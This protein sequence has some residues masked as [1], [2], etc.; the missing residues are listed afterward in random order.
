MHDVFLS[1]THTDKP[2][3]RRI[4]DALARERLTIWW[5]QAINAGETF[6]EVTAQALKDAA[7]IVVLWSKRSIESRWVRS[8]ATFADRAGKLVPVMI[9]P[10][11]RPIQFELTHTVDLL[12]WNGDVTDPRWRALVD[13]IRRLLDKQSPQS[14][15]AGAVPP[16]GAVLAE[17]ARARHR[18]AFVTAIAIALLAAGGW[19]IASHRTGSSSSAAT[20]ASSTAPATEVS[21]AVLPFADLSPAHDQEY[22]SD[23]LTAEI[24]DQLAQVPALRLVGRTSS[25]S[26]KGKN[27][28]LKTIGS[29]LGVT[30]LLE[31]SVRKDGEQLRISAQLVRA[32]DGAQVWSHTYARGLQDVFTAQEEIARD[33]AQALSVTLDVGTLSRAQGGTVNPEAYD[34]W[35][36]IK[37]ANLGNDFRPETHRRVV[38]LAREAV[39]LD[40]QFVLAWDQLA[41]SLDILSGYSEP[42]QDARL[43]AEAAQVRARVMAM[44]P[45]SWI[46]K[47]RRVE[48]ALRVRDWAAAESIA[49]EIL[50]SEPWAARD[51][52]RAYPLINVVFSLGRLDATIALVDQVKTREPLA[53]F[54]SRDQQFNYWSAGRLEEAEAEY[55]RSRTLDGDHT[56]SDWF[57]FIRMLREPGN[58]AA[59][60]TAYDKAA[61]QLAYIKWFG[62]LESSLDDRTRMAAILRDAHERGESNSGLYAAAAAVGDLDLAFTVLREVVLERDDP[63]RFFALWITPYPDV[64]S[65]PRFAQILR[66]VG[67]VDYWRRTGTWADPCHPV[68]DDSFECR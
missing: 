9:E 60:R 57:A 36:K 68:G 37:K 66:D 41:T 18:I 17:P 58:P 26:F 29:K 11:D 48:D 43:Q 20:T 15:G 46:A 19:W 65:D 16:S 44:A 13:G 30:N 55:Q 27:E 25:F 61:K 40:P 4:A 63:D 62:A 24:V 21:L 10:C 59:T 64:R 52:D 35:L 1:Y 50:K 67:L 54:V 49:A 7:V 34:R 38:Q 23:G 6:D 2:V 51:V 8:E 33:V 31:G 3:A 32:S 45:Q 47:R 5:D 22:F 12:D 53:M 56:Q 28:D 39:A 42:P 14:S